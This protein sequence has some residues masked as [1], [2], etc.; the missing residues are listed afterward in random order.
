[1]P[2]LEDNIQRMFWRLANGKFEPNQKDVTAM[3]QIVEWINRE[4]EYSVKHNQLLAKVYTR[5]F[6]IELNHHK[7]IE[8]A[9]LSLCWFLESSLDSI[10]EEFTDNLNDLEFQLFCKEIGLDLESHPLLDSKEKKERELQ[11][12]IENE[13][14]YLELVGGRWSVEKVT[15]SLNNQIS[16]AINLFKNK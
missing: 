13:K 5:L 14:R 3:K 9:Q 1:M 12:I 4:K 10:Y 2:T 8:L 15:K 6:W 11:I 7:D 16:N